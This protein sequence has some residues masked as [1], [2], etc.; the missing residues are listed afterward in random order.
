MRS[1]DVTREV[2]DTRK[3]T[4]FG[5]FLFTHFQL[6]HMICIFPV[7]ANKSSVFLR[8]TVY[9]ID[10]ALEEVDVGDWMYRERSDDGSWILLL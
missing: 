4:I 1:I 3:V 6:I 2:R 10:Y 7:S 9:Q 8:Y 5:I